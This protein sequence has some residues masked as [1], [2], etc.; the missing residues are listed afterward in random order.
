VPRVRAIALAVIR[1]P[2]TDEIFVDEIVDPATGR[3]FHRPAGGGIEF[4]ERASETLIRELADEYAFTIRVGRLLGALENHF[5]Y[6]GDVGHEIVLVHE[7]TL[8]RPADYAEDR[9]PCL[10][11]PH[12]TGVWRS[13]A[14]GDTP[15]Y[16]AGLVDI[17]RA[18]AFGRD[19]EV[20]RPPG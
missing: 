9:R 11:Q 1:R 6:A 10:D 13:L 4:G 3:L 8:T 17:I 20:V 12:I 5:T 16:P 19:E 2:G 18:L 14:D 15:L 7:A